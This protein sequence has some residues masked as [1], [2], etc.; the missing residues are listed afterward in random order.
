MADNTIDWGQG[1]NT[2]TIGWGAGVSNNTINWGKINAESYGNPE[3]DLVGTPQVPLNKI[4]VLENS[5]KIITLGGQN[6]I[7]TI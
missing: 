1:A 3:T 6:K 7:I 5:N 2:N 4:L